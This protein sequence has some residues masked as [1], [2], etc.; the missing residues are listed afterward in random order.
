LQ[1]KE[2][3][4]LLMSY[5]DQEKTLHQ[6]LAALGTARNEVQRHRFVF[7]DIQ[8]PPTAS[9]QSTHHARGKGR[10]G[11]GK[12][13]A[14][15]ENSAEDQDEADA[16]DDDEKDI[17]AASTP[18]VLSIPTDPNFG[19]MF[20]N[21]L[22]RAEAAFDPNFAKKHSKLLEFRHAVLLFPH[23]LFPYEYICSWRMNTDKRCGQCIMQGSLFPTTI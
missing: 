3:E 4:T 18:S 23:S 1:I 13:A 12:A 10:G 8:L 20:D 14:E 5:I 17:D 6:H 9:Q 16:A 22:Q 11:K 2:L 15:N 7:E 21:A 19:H